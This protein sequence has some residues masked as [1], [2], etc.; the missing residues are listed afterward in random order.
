MRLKTGKGEEREGKVHKFI[1]IWNLKSDR[2]ET[3]KIWRQRSK[4]KRR[5]R[6]RWGVGGRV[7]KMQKFNGGDEMNG[8]LELA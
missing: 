1:D 2:E 8:D 7:K 6:E 5:E 3:L 4:G